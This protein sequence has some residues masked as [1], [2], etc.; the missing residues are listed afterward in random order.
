MFELTIAI[1][2]LL[3]IGTFILFHLAVYI[4]RLTLPIR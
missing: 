4:F 1:I 2:S 3:M